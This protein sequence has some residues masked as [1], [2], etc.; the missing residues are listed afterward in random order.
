MTTDTQPL[1]QIAPLTT[2]EEYTLAE[3]GRWKN[4]YSIHWSEATR[5][6]LEHKGLVQS[7]N[8]HVWPTKAGLDAL[9]IL[10]DSSYCVVSLNTAIVDEYN[11]R[12]VFHGRDDQPWVPER[13]G[14]YHLHRTT[15][16][17]M[18]DDAEHWGNINGDGVEDV[19]PGARRMYRALYSKL[20]ELLKS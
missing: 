15:L 8:Q 6:L 7:D 19:T 17:A 18:R 13:P 10:K 1:R 4:Q 11:D 5:Q 3:I 2:R 20:T 16:A 12:E 9:Q 14:R